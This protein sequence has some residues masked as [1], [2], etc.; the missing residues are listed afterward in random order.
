MTKQM[1]KLVSF[2]AICLLTGT[3]YGQNRFEGYSFQSLEADA[4]SGCPIRYLSGADNRN[5]VQVFVAGTQQKTAAAGLTACGGS[6]MRDGRVIPN[7]EGKW[8]F[9]GKEE[10]YDIR[11]TTGATYLWYPVNKEAGFYNVK[12]FRPVTRTGGSTPQY[13]F[14]EP[15]DYTKTIRNA[16]AFIASRQGGTLRFPDG[17]YIVGTLD[18]E[19]RDQDY[20]AIT[21]PSGIIVEGASWNFSVPTT[22][23][24]IKTSATRIRLRNDNQAIFRIGGCTNHVTVRNIEL[25]GNSGLYGEAPRST[26]NTYGIEGMGKWEI[27]PR[28]GTERANQTLGLKV[29]NVTFQ[30]FDKGLYVHNA[31]DDRCNAREQRCNEWQI[32]FVVVDHGMFLN[33]KTG[34]WVESFNT[35]WKIT[36]SFL[37]YTAANAP[38]DGIRL[39]IAGNVLIEQTFGGGYDYGPNIGG[40]FLTVDIAVTVTIIASSSERGRRSIYTNPVTGVS[41]AMITVIG[42][43]FADKVQLKG[44]LN[45]VSTGNFYQANTIEA[46]PGIS[47]TSVGDRYCYDPLVLPGRCVDDAGR[48]T[49]RPA[50]SGG[51][52]MFETGQ[53]GEDFAANRIEGKPNYFG[54]NVRIGDGLLQF[55]PNITFRDIND[56]AA[57]VGARPRAEDGALVYCKDCRR[58]STGL[59]VQGTAGTDGSFARRINGQ[60]RCD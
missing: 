22:N 16:I 60:W 17:D 40:T 13:R 14:S 43:L 59:C 18:G 54:Y 8:C 30:N 19:R 35:D 48:P 2:V 25:L 57:G 26:A 27:D 34:I 52:K 4:A 5:A 1:V 10:M 42:S 32:D 37:G 29:E 56:W 6:A 55:D 12:D 11:V 36:N 38:G 33:N 39:K 9:Q 7:P 53:F 49:A 47:I 28:T 51:R 24:P 21:L 45:Y 15:A 31:N 3:I 41:S 50:I 58:A 23:L 44:R 46:D 20:Q